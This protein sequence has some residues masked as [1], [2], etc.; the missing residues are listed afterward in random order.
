M[1]KIL[2]ILGVSLF[3]LS[4]MSQED[5]DSS[6]LLRIG[7]N[8]PAFTVTNMAGETINSSE[9]QGKVVLINFFATWCPPCRAELPFVQMD[10]YNKYKDN[11]DF[12][13]MII[14]RE[15]KPEKV[16]P[17]VREKQYPMSFYS[18]IDRSCYKQFAL[19]FIPRNYLFDKN[20]KLVYHSKGFSEAEFKHLLSAI[21]GLVN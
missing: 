5:L 9:L 10:I 12:V 2:I 20:G 19:Q 18:D 14:S 1:R 16:I 7:H 6:N 3:A 17:F 8:M 11:D 15:E 4:A 13:L 21:K